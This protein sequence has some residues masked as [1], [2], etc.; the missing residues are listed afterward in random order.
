[1]VGAFFSVQGIAN[2]L[3]N[4]G[5]VGVSFFLGSTSLCFVNCHLTAGAEKWSRRN[6]NYFDI[7]S[8]LQLGQKRL[9]VMPNPRS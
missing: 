4:K 7:L 5:A 6:A 3:G 9:S 1:V 8:K 2:A